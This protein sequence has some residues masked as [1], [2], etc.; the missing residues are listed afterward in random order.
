MMS[1]PR[2]RKRSGSRMCSMFASEPVSK[3]STQITLCP[4]ASSS[5]HRCDPRKPAP[6]VT[7]QELTAAK[8]SDS[9]LYAARCKAATKEHL[10][11]QPT[12][13]ADHPR[14]LTDSGIEIAELYAQED[15]P[16]NLDL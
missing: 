8:L 2:C 11:D 10:T 13:S 4:R 6:P 1:T 3:L 5:S 9:S 16:E 12:A 15:L 14:R 7:R